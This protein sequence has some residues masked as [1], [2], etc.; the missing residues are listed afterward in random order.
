MSGST[1]PH[2]SDLHRPI[3]YPCAG[4]Q[5]AASAARQRAGERDSV[6][7]AVDAKGPGDNGGHVFP[8][9]FPSPKGGPEP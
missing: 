9:G 7:L 6:V 5:A 8:P 1:D 3:F 4:D 2:I